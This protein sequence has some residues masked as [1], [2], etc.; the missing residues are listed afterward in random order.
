MEKNILSKYSQFGKRSYIESMK[1]NNYS[2]INWFVYLQTID[3]YLLFYNKKVWKSLW[4]LNFFINLIDDDNR[5][6]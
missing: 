5:P 1:Q 4:F 3:N 2:G 6:L